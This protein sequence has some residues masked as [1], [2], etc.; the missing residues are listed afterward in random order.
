MGLFGKFAKAVIANAAESAGDKKKSD[1][2]ATSP[3]LKGLEKQ[4]QKDLEQLR[5]DR[6]KLADRFDEL[7]IDL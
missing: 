2:T 7:G 1:K 4:I 6:D 5:K 3:E